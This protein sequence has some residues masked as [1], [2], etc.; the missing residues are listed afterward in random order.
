MRNETQPDRDFSQ[1][2]A[3]STS[4]IGQ[5]LLN[6]KKCAYYYDDKQFSILAKRRTFFYLS[7]L[8]AALIK[9]PKPELCRRKEFVYTLNRHH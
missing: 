2:N 4:A 9:L 8:E 6:N 1:F 7:N 3:T 5:H